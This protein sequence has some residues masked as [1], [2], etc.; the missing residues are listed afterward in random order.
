MVTAQPGKSENEHYPS[1]KKMLRIV[2]WYHFWEISAKVKKL[3]EI[4][5]P[6]KA[7]EES[8]G[9]IQE[10]LDQLEQRLTGNDFI[11]GPDYSL[12]DC[13]Y[14]CL[15]A[16]LSM[17]DLLKDQ[18]AN[19]PNLATWWGKVQMRPSFKS[20]G[21]VAQGIMGTMAKKFCTIL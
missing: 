13:L 1:K 2:I 14:T 19:R 9:P 10:V 5:T 15:L 16:R 17:I 12:A 7:K 18:I 8:L 11:C 3:P 21:I 20:A 6:L 4:N